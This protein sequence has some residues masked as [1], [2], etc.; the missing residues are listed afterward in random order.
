MHFHLNLVFILNKI[1]LYSF[2]TN[3]FTQQK[4]ENKFTKITHITL[5][6]FNPF[7]G[8]RFE[9]LST[10]FLSSYFDLFHRRRPHEFDIK[11]INQLNCHV[12]ESIKVPQKKT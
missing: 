2:F 10:S 12:T 3:F 7:H 8:S 1:S 6:T 9:P 5:L 11:M 4:L